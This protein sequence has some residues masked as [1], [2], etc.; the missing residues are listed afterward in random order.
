MRLFSLTE[1]ERN[2][3]ET[4]KDDDEYDQVCR[5]RINHEVE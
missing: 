1:E 5:D 4:S 3:I 2:N